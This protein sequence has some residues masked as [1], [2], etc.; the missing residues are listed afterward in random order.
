MDLLD[1][2]RRLQR[3][4]AGAVTLAQL[5]RQGYTTKGVQAQVDARRWQRWGDGVVITYSGPPTAETRRWAAILACR[6]VAMLSHETAAELHG[7]IPPETARP[8]HVTAPYGTSASRTFDV[9]VHRSRAFAHIGVDGADPPVT[10]VPHTVLDLAVAEPDAGSAMRLVHR[11]AI[12]GRVRP[13]A[14]R[15]AI[16]RRR[17]R[18]YRQALLGGLELLVGGVSSELELRYVLDVE[19]AHRL[20]TGRRQVLAVVDGGNRYEDVRYE[21]PGGRVIVRLDGDRYHRDR[22]TTLIDRR[23]AVTAAVT[24]DVSIPFGWSEVDGHPCRTAREVAE[25]LRHA[26]W[27]G[28]LVR[29]RAC[30]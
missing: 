20:P 3:D 28:S 9:A 2:W 24:D 6:G 5:R 10:T 29:C 26:G 27:A 11:L 19:R 14:L 21:M 15:A 30:E 23:R 4:Q 7:L 12:A 16:D 25:V 17:P 13:E 18:R 22:T 1:E 8:I